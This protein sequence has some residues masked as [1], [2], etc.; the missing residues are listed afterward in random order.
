MPNPIQFID[1]DIIN[2]ALT[3]FLGEDR[4]SDLENDQDTKAIVMR[5]SYEPV[6]EASQTATPWRFNTHKVALNKIVGEP[7]SRWS[8]QWQLPADLLKLLFTWPPS[9][10]E[11]QGT[12]LYSNN[13]D[14]IEIDYQRKLAEGLW[15]TWFQRFVVASLV[16]RTSRGITGEKP[17]QDMLDELRAARDEAFFQDAQQQPNQINL[18]APFVDVRF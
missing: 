7:V 2:Q 3:G 1:L 5:E 10:Y 6:S 17:T 18:P 16:M 12:R 11:I 13:T 8:A 14:E 9:I 15:P 4:I